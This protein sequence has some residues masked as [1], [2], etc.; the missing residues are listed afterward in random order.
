MKSNHCANHSTY[1]FDGNSDIGANAWSD[2]GYLICERHLF[3]STAVGNL[4]FPTLLHKCATFSESPSNTNVKY[5]P[6]FILPHGHDKDLK[7]QFKI[8][9]I[10]F[11]Q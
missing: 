2:L 1:I 10:P 9:K 4:K 11:D 3:T 7:F 8:K 6:Y 5:H